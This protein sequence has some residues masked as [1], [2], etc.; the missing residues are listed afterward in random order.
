MG[1]SGCPN[2][3]CLGHS[4]QPNETP[5]QE[6]PDDWSVQVAD[7]FIDVHK[8]GIPVDAVALPW[9]WRD[10]WEG[11]ASEHGDAQMFGRDV[12]FAMIDKPVA[13]IKR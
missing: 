13:L 7:A 5:R 1:T 3:Q 12:L 6:L 2:V 11:L 10:G 8:W 4:F 9:A